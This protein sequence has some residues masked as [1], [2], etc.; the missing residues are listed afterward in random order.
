MDFTRLFDIPNFQANRYPQKVALAM[1]E[2]GKWITFS[3]EKL[4]QCIEQTSAT[5][6]RLGLKKGNKIALIGKTGSIYWN[7]L[8]FAA[9]LS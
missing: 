2:Q 3:S 8:D 9:H 1:L 4:V 5:L 6:L 7:V